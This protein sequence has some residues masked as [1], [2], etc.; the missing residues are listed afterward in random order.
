MEHERG[1]IDR[2]VSNRALYDDV[3]AAGRHDRPDRPPGDRRLETGYRIGRLLV[4]REVLGQAPPGF[5]AATKTFC[6]EF[7]QRVADFCARVCGP[8]PCWGRRGRPGGRVARNICYAP[9][10]T[11]MGGTTQILRNILGE[12]VLGLPREPRVRPPST[13][14]VMAEVAIS[15]VGVALA[16]SGSPVGLTGEGH[17]RHRWASPATTVTHFRTCPLCEATCGLEI[18]MTRRRRSARIRGDRDDV[19]SH[20]FICPKGSTAQA[21]PRG[22]RPAARVPM[23]ATTGDGELGRRSTWDEAFAEIERGLLPILERARPRRGGACTSATRRAQPRRHPLRPPLIQAL[24]TQNIYSASTVDQMPK[25]VSCGLLFGNARRHPG[26][27]PR[28]HR[29]PADAR[30]Q[31][32][33]VQRQPVHRARLPRSARGDPGARRAV[34]VVDPRRTRTADEPTST[35]P[36][37]R[38]PTPICCSPCST[39]SFAE[40]PASTSGD[41]PITSSASTSVARRWSRRSRPRRSRRSAGIDADT[42]RRIARELAGR[43]DGRG[44]RPHRHPHRRVRHARLVG[45]RRPQRA[46]RQPRPARRRDVPAGRARQRRPRG[47]PGGRGFSTGRHHSRVK[48]FPEVRGEFPVATLADEI[49][50]PG[51]GPGPRPHH[52]RRQPGAVDA[53]QRPARRGARRARLHGVASTSTSTRPPATP[54]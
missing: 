25:H 22:P 1:G 24:G 8:T 18:T 34:V 37:A 31:P 13:P 54:T 38:A 4:L 3:L 49:E 45:G 20:G 7:E 50:T 33:R 47:G 28:P 32:V 44:L 5:S 2:L 52:R 19:F 11:I 39:C 6:T 14:E 48:G 51:R 53:Q 42:I 26:A 40:R 17:D 46:H 10:Y 15:R 30:R 43:A 21:A 16:G 29:L 23:R 41:S 27:R 9:G 12:R 36:S 35:W